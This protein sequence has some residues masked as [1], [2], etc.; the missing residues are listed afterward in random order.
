MNFRFDT[1]SVKNALITTILFFCQWFAASFWKFLYSLNVI[2]ASKFDTKCSGLK[3]FVMVQK[4]SQNPLT[5]LRLK[6]QDNKRSNHNVPVWLIVLQHFFLV[7]ILKLNTRCIKFRFEIVFFK[8]YLFILSISSIYF[9]R[10]S[11]VMH[12]PSF[13]LNY[14]FLFLFLLSQFLFLCFITF[15]LRLMIFTF[16]LFFC[17]LNVQGILL[18]SVYI[19]QFRQEQY[20]S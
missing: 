6:V 16:S 12:A 14:S 2:I 10:N 15:L 1:A 5:Y 18:A 4:R 9:I 7:L 19:C 11:L 13:C 3:C 20:E 8:L 17:T